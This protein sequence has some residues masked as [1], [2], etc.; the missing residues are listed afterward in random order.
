MSSLWPLSWLVGLWVPR[1]V[2]IESCPYLWSL[3]ETVLFVQVTFIQSTGQVKAPGM[4]VGKI[5]RGVD[6]CFAWK[7]QGLGHPLPFSIG[8][9]L[10]LWRMVMGC[11]QS[12][13]VGYSR[14]NCQLNLVLVQENLTWGLSFMKKGAGV[15]WKYGGLLMS[16]PFLCLPRSKTFLSLMLGL[17]TSTTKT[18]VRFPFH[19]FPNHPPLTSRPCVQR[20]RCKRDEDIFLKLMETHYVLHL[21]PH[22]PL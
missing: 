21:R 3:S 20:V 16:P 1:S 13:L 15:A 22:R 8:L 10:N 9:L 17:L 11:G 18:P 5:S 4:G 19:L 7:V 2:W 12:Y 14:P 6:N